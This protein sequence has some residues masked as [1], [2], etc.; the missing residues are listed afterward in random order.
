MTRELLHRFIA[1]AIGLDLT[2]RVVD[3]ASG[4]PLDCRRGNLRAATASENQGNRGL[5]RD[6]STGFKGVSRTGAGKWTARINRDG[7]L[8][9]LGT[10]GT[11]S[12]AAMAYDA[13]ARLCFREFARLNFPGPSERGLNGRTVGT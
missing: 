12:E 6:Q 7:R 1:K 13:A 5:D 11:Q 8:R 3:H 9:H 10:Y 2:D 4:D